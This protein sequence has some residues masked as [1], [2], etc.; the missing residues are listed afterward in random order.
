MCVCVCVC[1]IVGELDL[2][3]SVAFFLIGIDVSDK[4]LGVVCFRILWKIK[5]CI[6]EFCSL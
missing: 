3:T 1:D 4:V 6:F 5:L 2:S